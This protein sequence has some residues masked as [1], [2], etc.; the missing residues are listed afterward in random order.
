M[1][2]DP[3]TCVLCGVDLTREPMLDCPQLHCPLRQQ[4]KAGHS[5]VHQPIQSQ[6]SATLTGLCMDLLHGVQAGKIGGL[7]LAQIKS[8]G[9]VT[10]SWSCGGPGASLVSLI[11]AVELLRS[12]LVTEAFA[13]PPPSAA[14]DS[15]PQGNA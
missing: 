13:M 15:P 3:N 9:S 10:A 6:G 5:H 14:F 1:P 11:G 8:D 7:A 2:D 4:E 12:R